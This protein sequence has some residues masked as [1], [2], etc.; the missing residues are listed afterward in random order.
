MAGRD[1]CRDQGGSSGLERLLRPR[2]IAVIGGGSWCRNVIEQCRKIGFG[3]EI[4]PVHP[5]RAT[6]GGVACFPDVGALPGVPDAAFV[7]V[8]REAT[9]AVVRALAAR[10]SNSA[11]EIKELIATSS[12]QV[13]NGV[14]LVRKTGEALGRFSDAVTEVASHV[15]EIAGSAEAAACAARCQRP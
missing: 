11:R 14:E 12:D 9:V 5:T 13:G 6:V 10:S 1:T 15:A 7:G 2:S 3:G 4:W 8:N